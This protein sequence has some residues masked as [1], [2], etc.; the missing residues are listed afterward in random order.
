[1]RR[2]PFLSAFNALQRV[3]SYSTNHFRPPI[4][5]IEDGTF[6]RRFPSPSVTAASSNPPFF[7]SLTFSLP[8][9]PTE[10]EH[11]AIIGPSNAGKTTLLEI[12]RGKHVCLPPTAR[13]F[14][15]LSSDGVDER[16]RSA[17]R[18]IQY[19]GFD[20]EQGGLGKK[21][22]RGA[23]M[24]ARYES[25][26]EDTDFSVLDYLQGNT[27][28]N[29]LEEQEGKSVDKHSLEEVIE[30]LRLKQLLSMPMSNLSNGQTRRARIARALMG[31][32]LVL[33]LDE[34]FMGLDP[35]TTTSLS[36]LLHDLAKAAAPRLVIA[37]RPQDPLPNWITHIIQLGTGLKVQY[38][39]EKAEIPKAGSLQQNAAFTNRDSQGTG[40]VQI[41]L[42]VK[43]SANV[44]R[45][46]LQTPPLNTSHEGFKTEEDVIEMQNV[47]VSYGEKEVLGD[48]VINLPGENSPGPNDSRKG[49]WWSVKRGERWGVFGPNGSGKTTLI[50]LICSD[51]PLSYSLPIKIFG[52]GRLPQPGKP[53]IS[54]FDIQARIG[55]SSPE[56]HAFFPR[57]VSLRRVVQNAWAETFLGTPRLTRESN[58]AVDACLRWFEAEL[59][60]AFEVNTTESIHTQK[61][62][63][64]MLRRTDWADE[65]K[66]GEV[67]FSAQRVALF[68]RAIVKEPEMVVLDEAFSGMDEYVRDKCML[69][70]TCGE[71]HTLA[72]MEEDPANKRFDIPTWKEAYGQPILKGLREDQT[73]ICVSHVK[74]E[75]PR[76]LTKWICL[77]EAGTGKP[78]RFGHF[79]KSLDEDP[80]QWEEIW[81]M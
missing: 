63:M 18:A 29:P 66:F 15:Y 53:G 20:G 25:R 44:R 65:L 28:L 41:G 26:R 49:L 4:I 64:L 57:N 5:A 54:I 34:P 68:L 6:Y 60:P 33:L 12:L 3:S 75:V 76:T 32:P 47:H 42:P 2:S 79:Q 38:Q 69:F 1:M 31:K 21:G 10:P 9:Y 8:S 22:T 56:I 36:P 70:L 16:L 23:Y 80:K 24:S 17:S 27:E 52:R 35:P 73:L 77:P 48:W 59:N 13:S 30:D 62:K 11:W 40:A 67:P 72:T 46:I 58:L 55:Q 78:A 7:P 14:P 43:I 61:T 74:E 71:T 50:S 51:H 81:G 45:P 19:V 37:L 39:G